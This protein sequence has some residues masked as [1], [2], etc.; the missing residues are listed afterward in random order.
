[1]NNELRNLMHD[2][3]GKLDQIN[4][5]FACIAFDIKDNKLPKDDDFI[6]LKKSHSGFENDFNK[7]ASHFKKNIK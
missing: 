3:R 1:M 7:L 4:T 5:C 2:L 6:D